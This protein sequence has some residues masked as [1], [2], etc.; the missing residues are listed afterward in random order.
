M[1]IFLGVDK[2][3][4]ALEKS[5]K[6]ATKHKR[7]LP[8]DLEMESI[9]LEELLSLVEDIHVKTRE[10]SQNTDLDMRE[11]LGVDKALQSIQGELLNNI[12][13]LTDLNERIKRDSKK[14][15]E[16]KN[17]PTYSDEQRQ[18]Y[19]DRLDDLNTEK[20]GLKYSQNRK[21]LQTQVAR[22]KQTLE[23]ILDKDTSL[24]ERIRTLI[25][26]QD[27]TT[28]SVLTAL[29][30][31]ISTIVLAITGVFGGDREGGQKVLHQKIRKLKKRFKKMVRQVSRCTQKIRRKGR[32]TCC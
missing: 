25:R 21:D 9:L 24:A 15:K 22:I 32:W 19:R 13:K 27:I 23:K 31:T 4:P 3:L 17:D 30:M 10:A 16:V 6:A 1:K 28:F 5:F 29:S 26:E 12:S 11:L 18:L 2:T 7:E 14:F 8:T 20:Q